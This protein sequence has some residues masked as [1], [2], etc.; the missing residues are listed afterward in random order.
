MFTE[1]Y[2][3]NKKWSLS[4][5]YNRNKSLRENHLLKRQKQLE[6]SL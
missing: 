6:A 2:I 4:C 5:T 3:K 1:L